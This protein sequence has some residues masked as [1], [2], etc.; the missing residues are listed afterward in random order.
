L[1]GRALRAGV[2]GEEAAEV[3]GMVPF[4]A[5]LTGVRS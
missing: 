1:P 2:L 5:W 4:A 3:L